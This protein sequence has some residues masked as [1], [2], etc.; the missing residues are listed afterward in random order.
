MPPLLSFIMA[1][2]CEKSYRA[3]ITDVTAHSLAFLCCAAAGMWKKT[4]GGPQ[5]RHQRARSGVLGKYTFPVTSTSSTVRVW[6]AENSSSS[7]QTP[8]TIYCEHGPLNSF[9]STQAAFL[10]LDRIQAIDSFF[11]I[12]CLEIWAQLVLY[13]SI[14]SSIVC[15][16]SRRLSASEVFP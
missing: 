9:C 1:T 3:C 2:P 15:S 4:F 7:S 14:Y 12:D 16:G 6:E 13:I 10:M 8:F 11:T 5:L